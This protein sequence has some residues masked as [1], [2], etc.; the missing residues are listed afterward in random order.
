M[1]MSSCAPRLRIKA[2]VTGDV[3][4]IDL[5]QAVIGPREALRVVKDIE[6]VS[7]ILFDSATSCHQLVQQIVKAYRGIPRQSRK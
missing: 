3:T 6:G 2:V 1:K 7:V 5:R 4:Q